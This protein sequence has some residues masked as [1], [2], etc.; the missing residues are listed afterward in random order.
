MSYLNA[1]LAVLFVI[2]LGAQAP[3]EGEFRLSG[4]V[5][6]SVTGQPL[7]RA[8]VSVTDLKEAPLAYLVTGPD[9]RFTITNGKFPATV[10][11]WRRGYRTESGMDYH[12]VP[13]FRANPESITVKLVPL[14]AVTGKVTDEN[15]DPL[16]G[17][18]VQIL[19]TRVWQGRR[20]T[21]QYTSVNTNDLGEYRLWHLTPGEYYLK[22]LGRR[23]VAT[24]VGQMPAVR[25]GELAYGPSYFSGVDSQREAS[26]VEVRPGES[27]QADFR[28]TGQRAYVVRGYLRNYV[29]L[30][31]VKV[32][33]RRGGDEVGARVRVNSATG[34][35]E[36]IDVQPGSYTVVASTEGGGVRRGTAE[37][38]VSAADVQG[39]E[40]RLSPG[41]TVTGRVVTS[42]PQHRFAPPRLLNLSM[43][44][45]DVQG[46][47]AGDRAAFQFDKV[48]PGRYQVV[49]APGLDLSEIRSG[50]TDVLREGLTVSEAGCE[51]LEV[52]LANETGQLEVELT[53]PAGK[54]ATVVLT[55][56][57]GDLVYWQEMYV[58]SGQA[59]ESPRVAPG[60]YRIYATPANS[61]L[62]YS[63]PA[64]LNALDSQATRVVVK[65]G[66]KTKATVG[67]ILATGERAPQ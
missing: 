10:K 27:T 12:Q 22:A 65:A 2:P 42:D 14:G 40:V 66:E 18:T 30:D 15:G 13:V 64:V 49:T 41:V 57:L 29:S 24:G 62:E 17:I 58:R 19:A 67:L 51:P 56:A 21:R 36:A 3:P 33:L 4:V 63:N 16:L 61:P 54:D 25:Q 26:R 50:T 53:G 8:S 34:A 6:D 31:G 59:Q 7:E 55:R 9:G 44:G 43:A 32:T 45:A 46:S 38:T 35:F 60:E 1:V 28:L 39:V 48:Q 52:T 5:L 37:V 20:T 23:Y 47:F 11:V